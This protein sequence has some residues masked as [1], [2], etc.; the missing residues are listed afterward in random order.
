MKPEHIEEF[1]QLI[2]QIETSPG[3]IILNEISLIQ[4]SLRLVARNRDELVRVL[5]ALESP[6]AIPLIWDVKKR[7]ELQA[8][9]EEVARTLHNFLSSAFSLVDHARNHTRRLYQGTEF[10]KEIQAEIDSRFIKDPDHNIAD[11]LRNYVLHVRFP[12]VTANL[13][14]EGQNSEPESTFQLSVAEMLKWDGWNATSRK[15]LSGMGEGLVL[16]PFVNRYFEKIESFYKWLWNRQSE[17]HEKEI[18]ATNKLR[19]RAKAIDDEP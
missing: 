4:Y 8:G 15:A 9:M 7:N 10:A 11:D 12:P 16:L 1:R 6:K 14:V 19:A 17:L 5:S 18:E 3:E 13:H 2:E